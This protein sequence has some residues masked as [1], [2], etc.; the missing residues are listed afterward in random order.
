LE[1]SEKGGF[2]KLYTGIIPDILIVTEPGRFIDLV[3]N[4]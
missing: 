1:R 3:C 2:E 4:F